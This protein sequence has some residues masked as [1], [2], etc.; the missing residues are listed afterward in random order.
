VD[1]VGLL[2]VGAGVV[3]EFLRLAGDAVGDDLVLGGGLGVVLG[4]VAQERFAVR[5]GDLIVV[6]VNFGKG[7]E[8]VAI[9]AVVDEGR[10][11]GRFDPRYLGE[12]DVAAQLAAGR[13]RIPRGGFL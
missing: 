11:Q 2:V 1:L 4:L 13:N 8:T 9:A 7:E 5:E 6:R 12:V 10:L 3:L